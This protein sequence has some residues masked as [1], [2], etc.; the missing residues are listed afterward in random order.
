[1]PHTQARR[2]DL[3]LP[4]SLIPWYVLGKFEAERPTF[5]GA[6]QATSLFWP[7][8]AKPGRISLLLSLLVERR[9]YA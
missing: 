1:M 2:E 9:N 8:E 7:T 4:R 5:F 6:C 3:W